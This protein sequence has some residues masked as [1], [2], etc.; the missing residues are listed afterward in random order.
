MASN[1]CGNVSPALRSSQGHVDVMIESSC[2]IVKHWFLK[3][4]FYFK[5]CWRTIISA[6]WRSCHW[7][8]KDHRVHHI[9][10]FFIFFPLTKQH[11]CW[12]K[13]KLLVI[14]FTNSFFLRKIRVSSNRHRQLCSVTE[15]ILCLYSLL[16]TIKLIK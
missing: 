7:R 2:S 1:V 9:K 3:A 16:K 4:V 5:S 8:L 14:C 6:N 15:D 13:E 11:L 10:K 12:G